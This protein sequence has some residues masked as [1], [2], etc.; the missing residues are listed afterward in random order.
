MFARLAPNPQG[1]YQQI[2]IANPDQVV[3]VF[4]CA[5]PAPHLGMLDR[6][7]GDCREAAI[8]AIIVANKID[9]VGAHA[10]RGAV[11]PLPGPGLPAC[12][13]LQR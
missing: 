11:R 7:P 6:Y 5:E 8:P 12:C 4:A 13:I 9:L 2:L 10:G 1:E 3:L